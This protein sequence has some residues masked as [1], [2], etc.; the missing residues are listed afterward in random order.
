MI[1]KLFSSL[2][3]SL[4]SKVE[5]LLVGCLINLKDALALCTVIGGVVTATRYPILKINV[6]SH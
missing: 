2:I 4:Y 6:K 3:G 5:G 1:A